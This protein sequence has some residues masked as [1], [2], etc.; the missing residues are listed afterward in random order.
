MKRIAIFTLAA[1]IGCTSM[2]TVEQI[3]TPQN[4]AKCA[5]ADVAATTYGL[6]VNRMHEVD[7][8]VKALTIHGLGRVAG[9][10]IPVIGL[11]IA[12]YYFLKWLDKSTVTAAAAG[13]TCIAAGRV[14][15]IS[16]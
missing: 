10:V 2:P 3:G 7:P 4:F 6:A 15:W 11:S 13:V 5:T 9:T 14:L 12:G 8:L 1:L 16:R